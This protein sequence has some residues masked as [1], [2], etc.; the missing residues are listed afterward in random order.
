MKTKKYITAIAAL[1]TLLAA[2][3]RDDDKTLAPTNL[4]KD[5]LAISDSPDP[6]DH[7]RYEIYRDLGVSVYY[8]DTIGKEFRYI[9][10]YGDSVIHVEKVDPFYSVTAMDAANTY[11]LSKN[12][13]E[14]RLATLFV[15]DSIISAL[16]PALYPSTVLLTSELTL[17]AFDTEARGKR[18]G[19]V[20]N[21]YRSVIISNTG[22]F[23]TM[24]AIDK[25]HLK[26]EIVATI[27]YGYANANFNIRLAEFYKVSEDLFTPQ[28]LM[29]SVYYLLIS[30][31]NAAVYRPHWN[32]Y[33]FLIS[34]PNMPGQLQANA[35]IP[36]EYTRYYTPS[37]E[38]D[39]SSFFLAVFRYTPAEFDAEY[40]TLPGFSDIRRKY[41]I[42]RAITDAIINM[43]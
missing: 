37:K 10:V 5:W 18:L 30:S 28:T 39:A 17:N 22:Q 34:S 38:E 42:I 13:E 20:Y 40:S 41:D 26:E 25:S 27:C 6:L 32:Y 11:L 1:V 7:L 4:D 19:N 15:R 23:S 21:G 8:T 29:P 36:G 2:C 35:N 33:A 16:P 43:P 12:R 9:N 3:N 31:G 14:I 24:S